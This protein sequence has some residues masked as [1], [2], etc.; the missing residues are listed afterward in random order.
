M[1]TYT[2]PELVLCGDASQAIQGSGKQTMANDA[3][4]PHEPPATTPA[5]EADE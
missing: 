5:Y 1:K 2:K 4:V 3:Q